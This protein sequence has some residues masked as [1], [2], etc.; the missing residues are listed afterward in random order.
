MEQRRRDNFWIQQ[1][2][3]DGELEILL[4]EPLK[5]QREL[6]AI[7]RIVREEGW[8]RSYHTQRLTKNGEIRRVMFTRTAIKDMHGKLIG[9]S[10]VL[11]VIT[12]TS[13]CSSS[14]G[15]MEKLSAMGEL[16]AGIAHEIKNR[17]T[18]SNCRR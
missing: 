14:S 1:E 3:L 10:S 9:F 12:E 4:P 6:E 18:N 11:E 2:M 16:S 17:R 13:A 15:H 8:L 5:A 7:S